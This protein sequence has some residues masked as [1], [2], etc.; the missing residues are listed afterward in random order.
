MTMIGSKHWRRDTKLGMPTT[1]VPSSRFATR[2]RRLARL[3][4]VFAAGPCPGAGARRRALGGRARR[5]RNVAR[6]GLDLKAGQPSD[7]ARVPGISRVRGTVRLF[8][9]GKVRPL[10]GELA[11]GQFLRL[12]A[13]RNRGL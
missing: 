2:R 3:R 6:I 5:G 8:L 11:A 7:V 12:E 10:L 1:G 4:P 9:G 13:I